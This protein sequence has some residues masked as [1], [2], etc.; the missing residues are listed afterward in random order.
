MAILLPTSVANYAYEAGFRGADLV[1]MV[2]IAGAESSYN[3]TAVNPSSGAVGLWQILPSAHPEFAG[4]NLTDPAVNARAAFSVYSHAPSAGKITRNKWTVYEGL[5]YMALLPAATAAV[6]ATSIP[7]VAQ[8]HTAEGDAVEE[9]Q[10]VAGG[11]VDTAAAASRVA[12]DAWSVLSTPRTWL[13]VAYGVAGLG[14]I[15]VALLKV[16]A[17]AITNSKAAQLVAG[18]AKTV[19]T[20]GKG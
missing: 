6:A 16:E 13:R 1:A 8:V 18:T 10:Q 7:G 11:A 14:L 17:G 2:A 20:K 12:G 9:A 5:R 15:W 4:Q 3:T 19:V